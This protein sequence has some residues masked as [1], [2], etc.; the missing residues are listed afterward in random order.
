MIVHGDGQCL[1]RL[2][3]P[4]H[5]LVENILDLLGRRDLGYRL[6]Y[7]AFLILRQNLVAESN[8]LVAYV[9]RRSGNELSDR[10]LRLSTERAAKMFL[11]G[12]RSTGNE[13]YLPTNPDTEA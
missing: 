2:L 1:L 10:V 5:V 4:D 3:L 9:N 11:L 8:D 13:R 7:L 6:S 12:H